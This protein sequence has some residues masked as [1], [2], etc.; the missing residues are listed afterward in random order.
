MRE[1]KRKLTGRLTIWGG[2]STQTQLPFQTPDEVYET[3]K[4]AI[5]VL[6]AGGGYIAAPTHEAPADIPPENIAAI[7][8]AFTEQSD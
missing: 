2:I 4:T 6:G 7:V 3:V 8:R 5:A 1:Y